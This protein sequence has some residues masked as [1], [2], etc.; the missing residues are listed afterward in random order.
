MGLLLDYFHS[1][2]HQTFDGAQ[3]GNTQEQNSYRAAAFQRG[4][5]L[6]TT[7]TRITDERSCPGVTDADALW[8]P[9]AP[10]GRIREQSSAPLT[11]TETASPPQKVESSGV[12]ELPPVSLDAPWTRLCLESGALL[13]GPRARCNVP[14]EHAPCSATGVCRH[15]P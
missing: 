14:G 4:P 9:Y 6:K 3:V 10:A 12:A 5:L 7:L 11:I 15:W 2:G 13:D 1:S 8:M